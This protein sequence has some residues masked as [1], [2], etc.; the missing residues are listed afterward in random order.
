MISASVFKD[1]YAAS[2]SVQYPRPAV[3]VKSDLFRALAARTYTASF[4]DITQR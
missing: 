2:K 4:F 1:Q 3:L